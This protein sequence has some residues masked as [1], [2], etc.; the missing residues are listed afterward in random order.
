LNFGGLVAINTGGTV[1]NSYWDT[2]TSGVNTSA[3]S[4]AGKTTAEM[5]QQATFNTWDFTNTWGIYSTINNGYP[6]IKA[7]ASGLV[8]EVIIPD[9]NFFAALIAAGVDLNNDGIIQTDEAAVVTDLN[10]SNL[11]ISN[12]QGIETFVSLSNLDCSLNSISSIDLS[13]ITNLTYFDCSFNSL[14]IINLSSNTAL[15]YLDCSDN[16]LTDLDVSFNVDLTYLDCSTNQLTI[17]DVTN[18]VNLVGLECYTNPI[19]TINTNTNSLLEA[20]DCSDTQISSLDLRD[21]LLL[22]LVVCDAN[23]NLNS[24]CIDITHETSTWVIDAS[25]EWVDNCSA[26]SISEHNLTNISIFPNPSQTGI[27]TID[28]SNENTNNSVLN[29]YEITGKL[30]LSKKLENLNSQVNLSNLASGIY[31]VEIKSENSIVKERI[32]ICK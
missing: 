7:N 32:V 16:L 25:A 23:P 31:S 15:T 17:L 8:S 26:L 19:S 3:R 2:E 6:F 21:N 28:L 24:I 18:N 10:I 1:T 22:S 20:L 4:A 30:I 9:A 27:F 13:S 14:T 11:A 5:K 29:I 12:I